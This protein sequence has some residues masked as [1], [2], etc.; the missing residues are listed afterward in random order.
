[1]HNVW[2]TKATFTYHKIKLHVRDRCGYGP[3]EL[4]A[5]GWSA[6]VTKKKKI[7]LHVVISFIARGRENKQG[8]TL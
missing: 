5:D 1:M 6:M 8:G 7:Y 3:S 2:K 4:G